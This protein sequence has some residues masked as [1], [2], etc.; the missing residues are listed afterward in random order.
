MGNSEEGSN[1]NEVDLAS[2][3][4]VYARVNETQQ[5]EGAG[6]WSRFNILVSLHMVLF[7]AVAFVLSSSS[8]GGR[9]L[10]GVLSVGACF[11]SLWGVYVLRRLWLWHTH[12]K[13][14]L[15][16]IE[17]MFPPGLP[18]PFADRPAQLRKSSAWYQSWLLAYT[19][20]FMLLLFLVWLTIAVLVLAGIA[21]P[22]TNSDPDLSLP[23]KVESSAPQSTGALGEL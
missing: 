8:R 9:V 4:D 17:T 1:R 21:L 22:N 2:I 14:M 3:L 12:W 10:V 7:G 23:Y 15:Q 5:Y 13:N 19:Q 20:P 11:L 16:K 18:R 6:I